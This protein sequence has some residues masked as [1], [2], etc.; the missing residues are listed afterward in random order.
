MGVDGSVSGEMRPGEDVRAKEVGV[1]GE[2]DWRGEG[3]GTRSD[4][5]DSTL[6]ELQSKRADPPPAPIS[7]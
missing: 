4:V 5:A 6:T 7:L 3:L 1:H 2:D